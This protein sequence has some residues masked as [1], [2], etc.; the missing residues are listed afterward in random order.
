MRT[1]QEVEELAGELSGYGWLCFDPHPDSVATTRV[2]GDQRIVEI[3]FPVG[4]EPWGYVD[5][6]E[7]WEPETVRK[8]R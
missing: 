4:T 1:Q 5:I 6:I 3:R 8:H 7:G 2:E